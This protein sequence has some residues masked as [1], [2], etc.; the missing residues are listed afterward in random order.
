MRISDWSSDVCSSDLHTNSLDEAVALPTDFSAR[1]ARNTQL[2]LQEETGMTHV[3]DPLGGS[4]YVEA[5]TKDLADKAWALIEEVEAAGG[6]T[7]AVEKGLPKQHIERAAAARQARV[8]KGEDVIVGVNKYRLAAEDE[9]DILEI[10]NAKVSAD[11]L[12]RIE[13]VKAE[14]D[15]GR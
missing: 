2:I 15:E 13:R 7:H 14:R 4:Y 5:L 8:D 10:D 12:R 9:I 1:I 3:V 6:M 11:Q